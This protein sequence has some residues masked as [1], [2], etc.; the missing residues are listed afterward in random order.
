MQHSI[1]AS[2]VL[3]LTISDNIVSGGI[4][5]NG[6]YQLVI[7]NN[8]IDAPATNC[9]DGGCCP[10]MVSVGFGTDVVVAANNLTAGQGCHPIGVS[11]W[12]GVEGYKKTTGMLV[13]H[14]AFSGSFT[15]PFRGQP[16]AGGVMIDGANGVTI[17]SN[18]FSD[19]EPTAKHVCDCCE[20]G[21]MAMCQNITVSN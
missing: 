8:T 15:P 17:R 10:G 5:A 14:N 21:V 12:G 11:I 7:T 2:G 18:V 19:G 6:D 1:A 4:V 3:N 13:A 20:Y 16:I 9:P